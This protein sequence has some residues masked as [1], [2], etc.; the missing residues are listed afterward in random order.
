MVKLPKNAKYGKN[1]QLQKNVTNI[2]IRRQET[3]N[4]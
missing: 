3:T 2:E 4:K 1:Y